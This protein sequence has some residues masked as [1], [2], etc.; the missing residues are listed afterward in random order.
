MNI[1]F[2]QGQKFA[3]MDNA[4]DKWCDPYVTL[5]FGNLEYKTE[6]VVYDS[7]THTTNINQ[8]FKVP[9]QWP[10]PV[11]KLALKLMDSDKD[12][13]LG[14]TGDETMGSIILSLKDIIS[15]F[16]K[17]GGGL[18]WMNIYG[19]PLGVSITPVKKQMNANPEI[20]SLWKG[21]LLM[22]IQVV[23]TDSPEALSQKVDHSYYE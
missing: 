13:L 15:R 18:I 17:R 3:K 19:S 4:A 11:D 10:S 7:R 8:V 16:S 9:V 22:H 20:A 14:A 21:R 5:K 6:P 23:D 2:L 12:I 1:S